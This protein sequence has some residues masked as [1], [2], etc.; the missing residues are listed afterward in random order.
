MSDNLPAQPFDIKD[1]KV[2][3][4][5]DT[6]ANLDLLRDMLKPL[7]AQIFFATS[8]ATAL[9]IAKNALPDLILL[10]IM[11]PDM[12]G[13]ETCRQLKA[14]D[15]IDRIPV[16]FVTAKTEA[17]DLARG[18][19]AGGIDYITK[20]IRQ[21]EVHARVRAHLQIQGLI[22][23]QRENLSALERAKKEL[24]ELNATKDKFLSSIGRTL[25]DSLAEISMA[26]SALK[27][28]ASDERPAQGDISR[29]ADVVN[30]SA[31]T[32]LGL[33]E[34][35]LE[36]PRVQVGQ[37]LDL[38]D[39]EIKDRD[40]GYLVE[41]LGNLRFL[42]LAGT[43]ITD[44]GLEYITALKDLQELH[45]DGTAITDDGLKQLQRLQNLEVLDLK[46]TVIT[47][48]GLAR[49]KSLRNLKGLYLTRTRITDAGLVHVGTLTALRTLILWDT[50]ITDGGLSELRSLRNLQELILWKT[51]V[52]EQGADK[53]RQVL[54]DCDVSVGMF[55]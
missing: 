49:L 28:C 44:A 33:L 11:M 21:P 48:D 52:T 2:L 23:Q 35:I 31:E 6:P 42:S 18:F 13:L 4:V 54:P 1:A 47:D 39:M 14:T 9:N 53:L 50:Q 41:S 34:N 22:R 10:D 29:R 17:E 25:R 51:L 26:S 8:G 27:A 3:I 38:L 45:L 16:I 15:R 5:D 46:D 12:D 37:K 20:P 40:L 36:W 43:R 30:R 24:Q 19:E 32:V 55:T 7:G